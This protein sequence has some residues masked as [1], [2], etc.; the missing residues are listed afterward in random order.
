MLERWKEKGQRWGEMSEMM[1]GGR[2]RGM[3]TARIMCRPDFAHV[4]SP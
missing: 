2:G 3:S 4:G 1:T